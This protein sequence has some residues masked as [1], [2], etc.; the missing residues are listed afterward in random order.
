MT[1][2]APT[3]AV[4][5]DLAPELNRELDAQRKKVD[6]DNFDVTVRELVRMVSDDELDRAPEYQRQ[7]RWKEEQESKL[8]ESIFLGLPV[9]TIFVA[10]NKNGTWEI[11]DGLQR[12]STLVHYVADPP[13][14]L[15]SID[16]AEP[17]RLSGLEKLPAFNGLMFADLPG[18]L[19]L[20]F[21]KRPL[22]V[23]ALS[24]KSDVD[25]RFD[26]FERLNTGGIAL[27]PQEI[28]ACIFRGKFAEFLEKLASD[29]N[30][31]RIVKLKEGN[32][33]D[34]TREEL[35]LKFFAYLEKRAEFQGKVKKFLNE[36]MRSVPSDYDY[37]GREA[38]FRKVVKAL[39]EVLGGPILRKDVGWSPINLVEAVLVGG[40]EL[41][42]EGETT[43]NPKRDWLNDR[44]L[45]RMS[46]AGSNTPS[47]L[48]GRIDR[49]RDLLNG[50]TPESD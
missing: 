12:V 37:T 50:S 18:P 1:E 42:K 15:R 25:V 9:P 16:K 14:S 28:R 30:F 22:R 21:L 36:Y 3:V 39:A 20:S 24:D 34:G 23:T 38:F 29:G 19:Q 32:E 10:T 43:F 26:M 41:L 4:P 44:S 13:D 11:V 35:I 7:F 48:K 33:N 46:S 8:V 47:Y 5:A 40:A 49:A 31:N 17:L 2:S 45:T 6:S 27:T